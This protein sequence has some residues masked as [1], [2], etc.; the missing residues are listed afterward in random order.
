TSCSSVTNTCPLT[1][2]RRRSTWCPR[3]RWRWQESWPV[4]RNVLV[5]GGSR[6]L[7]LGLARRL[8]GAGY[9]IRAGARKRNG[10]LESAIGQAEAER[11]QANAT[12]QGSFR[13]FPFDLA[14][15]EKIPDLVKRVRAEVGPIYGLVNNAALGTNGALALMHVSH[16][17]QLI[18]LNTVSPIVLTKYVVRHMMSNGDGRVVNIASI[19]GFTGYKGLTVYGATKASMIGFTRS[20]AREA[21]ELG[22]T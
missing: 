14:E 5:T 18:R 15:I 21:G 20:L 9:R 13:F 4:V 7:G 1:R 3:S 17:E 22:I 2:F 19:L 6:G 12:C 10:P 16:I 8:G 11:E